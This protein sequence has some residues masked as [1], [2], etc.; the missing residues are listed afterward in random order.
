MEKG[1]GVPLQTISRIQ[2][3]YAQRHNIELLPGPALRND[4]T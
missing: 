4:G 1:F 2:M 3:T